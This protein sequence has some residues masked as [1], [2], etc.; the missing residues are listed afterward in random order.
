MSIV[1]RPEL[2][3]LPDME[4]AALRKL[5]EKTIDDPIV[6]RVVTHSADEVANALSAE[7]VPFGFVL[8]VEE[9]YNDPRLEMW[10]MLVCPKENVLG[11]EP[12]VGNPIKLSDL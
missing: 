6:E 9:V 11:D 4:S 5:Q 8:T 12:A 7:K 1:G 2:I 3:D 10:G